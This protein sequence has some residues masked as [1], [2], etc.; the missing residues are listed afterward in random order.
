MAG[1]VVRAFAVVGLLSG[2][3]V[4]TKSF[5]GLLPLAVASMWQRGLVPGRTLVARTLLATAACVAVVLPWWV[6]SNHAFPA[7]AAFERAYSLRHLLEPLE[8]HGGSALYHLGRLPRIYGELVYLPL[9]WFVYRLVRG[10]R[11]LWPGRPCGSS[12]TC[13]SL[14]RPKYSGPRMMLARSASAGPRP[15]RTSSSNSSWSP[16]PGKE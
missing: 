3:A 16:E 6:Y 1:P 10:E 5:R 8:G 13:G 2:L 7:Q 11:G 12:T 15:A 9:T 14:E 4:L